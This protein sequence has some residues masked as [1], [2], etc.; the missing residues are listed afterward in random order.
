MYC[1][2]PYLY[3]GKTTKKIKNLPSRESV[4]CLSNTGGGGTSLQTQEI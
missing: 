1:H 2:F 4:T 3:M